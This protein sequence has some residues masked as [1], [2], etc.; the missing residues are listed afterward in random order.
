MLKK[1]LMMSFAA[2]ALAACNDEADEGVQYASSNPEIVDGVYSGQTMHFYGTAT[3]T[4]TTDNSTY[5]DPETWFEIHG[6]K[7]LVVYMHQTRFAASM[8]A[9]EM[10]IYRIPYTPGEGASL[11][12]SEPTFTPEAELPNTEGGGSS[13]QEVPQFALTDL[14][15]S[16]EE[17]RLHMAFTCMGTY[18]MEYEGRLLVKK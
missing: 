15:G 12:F 7:G 17:T 1:L 16:I 9:Q 8:P 6:D 4:N 13:Y 18:R 10:R 11:S 14:E 2:F 5:T 3:V